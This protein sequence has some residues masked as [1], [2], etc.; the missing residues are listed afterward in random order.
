M[1]LCSSS[2]LALARSS[3]LDSTLAATNVRSR[4]SRMTTQKTTGI[5]SVMNRATPSVG[6]KP[7][8]MM[9]RYPLGSNRIGKSAINCTEA[10]ARG[11]LVGDDGA[12]HHVQRPEA[13][14]HRRAR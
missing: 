1:P 14:Q 2:T 11:E 12:D 5:Q 8:S 13:D 10:G 3:A 7:G 6:S 9:Y 4:P